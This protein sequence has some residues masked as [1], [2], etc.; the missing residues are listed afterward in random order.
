MR[1]PSAN[2]AA[3]HRGNQVSATM[4][5]SDLPSR[6]GRFMHYEEPHSGEIKR[7]KDRAQ[8][9]RKT[10]ETAELDPVPNSQSGR[11]NCNGSRTFQNV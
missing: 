8:L 10:V 5:R 6:F 11:L 7:A 1:A 2:A 3:V 4:P 9:S